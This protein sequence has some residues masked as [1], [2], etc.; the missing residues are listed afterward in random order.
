MWNVET[1]K[2]IRE[3]R[4]RQ[5]TCLKWFKSDSE[6]IFTGGNG[7]SIMSTNTRRNRGGKMS[8]VHCEVGQ[9]KRSITAVAL[10]D[11]DKYA[12]CG[13]KSGDIMCVH[14]KSAKFK[15][16][17]KHKVFGKCGV[18]SI[19]FIEDNGEKWLLAGC[20][21]GLV[22]HIRLLDAT[23]MELDRVVQFSG[24]VTSISTGVNFKG[25]LD[26]FVGMYTMVRFILSSLSLSPS[27]PFPHINFSK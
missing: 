5:A 2:P 1:G 24:S 13:T 6:M 16:L 9:Y 26:T 23:T 11:E 3:E 4:T 27:L 15:R 17:F 19:E 14:T 20:G 7:A 8:I 22:G 18:Q 21:D 25:G 12:Y 10:D